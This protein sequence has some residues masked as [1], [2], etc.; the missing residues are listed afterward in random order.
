MLRRGAT[1]GASQASQR[2]VVAKQ[3]ILHTT[4][5]GNEERLG[6]RRGW[7]VLCHVGGD[8]GV[9]VRRRER[10]KRPLCFL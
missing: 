5:K 2:G 1:R 4:R 6:A 9:S 7:L 10:G 8:I 3:L